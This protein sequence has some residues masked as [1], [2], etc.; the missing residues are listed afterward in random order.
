MFDFDYLMTFFIFV[1]GTITVVLS[2]SV[3]F[4]FA[5]YKRAIHGKPSKLSNAVAW[6]LFGEAVIGLGTLVFSIAAFL[7]EL[8]HWDIKV[9]S[10]LRLVMFL[11]TGLTTI[12][13]HNTLNKMGD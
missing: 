11:A 10:T 1:L 8:Q 12:H 13:L 9:Q 5:K 2:I 3:S 7:G 6:Q 4:K